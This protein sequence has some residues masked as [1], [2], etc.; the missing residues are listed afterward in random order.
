MIDPK[1]FNC[2][3]VSSRFGYLQAKKEDNGQIVWSRYRFDACPIRNRE[4]AEY[5]ARRFA[6]RYQKFNHATGVYVE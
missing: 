6:G 4:A 5:L 1:E 2:L 3:I